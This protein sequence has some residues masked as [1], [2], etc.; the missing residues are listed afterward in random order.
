MT[1]PLLAATI[2]LLGLAVLSTTTAAQ[3]GMASDVA[4]DVSFDSGKVH[5][6]G[7]E[8]SA[9]WAQVVSSPGAGSIRL[10]FE[11]AELGHNGLGEA[12]VLRLTSLHDGAIQHH[13]NETL[14]QWGN[15][16]AY[17]NG[18]SVLVEIVAE[19]T[20]AVSRVVLD[21]VAIDQ[22][23]EDGGIASICGGTDDRLPSND[24]RGG[25]TIPG[26]CS[27]WLI[28]DPNHCFLTAGHCMSSTSIIEFNVP[29]SLPD[30]TYQHAP[31][32]DQYAVDQSSMQ[33][34]SGGIGNDW[35]YFG[36]FANTE[37]GL[38]AYQAQGD[39][40]ELADVAPPVTGQTI[41]I[42]GYGST[43]VPIQG[44]WDGVQKTHTGPYYSLE[45]TTLR[46]TV[47][48]TGGNSG[49][50]VIDETTGK[51]IGIHT[52]A[53][54]DPANH[55]TAVQHAGLQAAL[56]NPQGVCIP[57]PALVIT[58][59]DGTPTTLPAATE[60]TFAVEIANGSEAYDPGSALLYYRYDGGAFLS[61]PLTSPLAGSLLNAALPAAA[62]DDTPEFYIEAMGD[63]GAVVRAPDDAPSDL[64]VAVVGMSDTRIDDDF[65]ADLGWTT[66]VLGATTG[67]WQRGTPVDDPGWQYD[68]ISDSD[69]SGQCYLTQNE[70]GNTDVDDGS[71]RLMSP[72]IDLSSGESIV[73][74]DYFLRL[75]NTDGGD[76]M[77]VE[78]S[79]N[80]DA[81]PWTQIALHDTD[82]ALAWRS[83]T[84]DAAD[85]ASAG[86]TPGA[87][88]RLR[89]TVNDADP[90]SIVE[91]GIDHLLARSL[92]CND[93]EPC[94]TDVDG[95]GA[96]DVSDL[97]QVLAAWGDTGGVEDVDGSGTVD[98]GDMLAVLAAWG[99]CL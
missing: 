40:Y 16:S 30:G 95:N 62:C 97:L 35:S 15:T 2:T 80:D 66:E 10:F 51:A 93:A 33:G 17:F 23:S 42:T 14:A 65:E 7:S 9:V 31:P 82:G 44:E 19:P 92:V 94:P 26:G 88:M 24:P 43:T 27:A 6:R 64:F 69:G 52:H 18:D 81:G 54:C 72:L 58:F 48:T 36:C 1:R 34:I 25:R 67:Q 85:F 4:V 57:T 12:T 61:A 28:D 71:V 22:R 45:D 55:G 86:V 90:P 13:T 84:I 32:E 41:R 47:D 8:R 98:V 77:L 53:G 96:T 59:P 70:L 74:Y 99:D 11:T 50:P 87:T 3:T 46:Y 60:T 76:R 39:S 29:F 21:H 73:S 5:A 75:T 89:F 63:E 83:V 79:E 91:A 56:A 68:P 37:T 78:A 38:T 20:A 49:S